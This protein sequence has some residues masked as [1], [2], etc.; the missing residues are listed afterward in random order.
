MTDEQ[1]TNHAFARSRS[2]DGLEVLPVFEVHEK[3]GKV[4]RI[5]ANGNIEGFDSSACVVNRVFIITALI[6]DAILKI[7]RET[8]QENCQLA[9][10]GFRELAFQME[11]HLELFLQRTQQQGRNTK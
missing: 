7:K 5:F 10:Q 1:K 4:F 6:E 8:Q 2:N 3:S 11:Q 9:N